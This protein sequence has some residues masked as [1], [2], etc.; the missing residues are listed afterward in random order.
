M[1]LIG[2]LFLWLNW[3]KKKNVDYFHQ[4]KDLWLGIFAEASFLIDWGDWSSD[5]ERDQDFRIDRLLLELDVWATLAFHHLT[6]RRQFVDLA[7]HL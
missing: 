4:L 2:H 6:F 5:A 1:H 7:E 3:S